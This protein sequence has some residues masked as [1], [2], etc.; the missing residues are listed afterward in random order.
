MHSFAPLFYDTH[1]TA[2]LEA[3]I[4]AMRLALRMIALHVFIC[5]SSFDLADYVSRLQAQTFRW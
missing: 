2:R 1:R 5:I 4:C 3:C